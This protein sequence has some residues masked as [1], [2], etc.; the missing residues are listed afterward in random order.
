MN[1]R[2]QLRALADHV[3]ILPDYYDICGVRHFTD[4][5]TYVSL[6]QTLSLGA[7]TEESAERTLA[8]LERVER[9]R[10]LPPVRVL[11][12]ES[13]RRPRVTLNVPNPGAGSADWEIE[14]IEES[15][16]VH[17]V[18]SRGIEDG[19]VIDVELPGTLP[20]GYHT[21]R[22]TVD[23][24]TGPVEGEQSFIVTPAS[25]TSYRA[26]TNGRRAYGVWTNAYTLRSERNW[27]VGDL[28]DIAELARG[29]AR[30]G[31]LFVGLNPLHALRNR[32]DEV[33]PY[34]PISRLFR[35]FIYVDVEAVP[36]LAEC[37]EA[38]A[39]CSSPDFRAELAR[40]HSS[41]RVEYEH[42]ATIKR[43]VLR[44]LHRWFVEHHVNSASPRGRAFAEY[45]VAQGKPLVNFATFLAI[46]DRFLADGRGGSGWRD[47]PGEYHDPDSPAVQEFRNAHL[48]EIEFHQYVQFELDRQ[49]AV[50]GDGARQAG[51]SL[52]LYQDLAIGAAD[53]GSD[54][55]SFPGLF[56]EGI[57]VGAPPDPYSD[58]GQTWGFP[59]VNP[60]RLRDGAYD[61]WI[62]LLRSATAHTK[63]L[64]IDHVMG[65]FRQFWVPRGTTAADGAYVKFP[66][67]DLLGILALES[68][69]NGTVVVGEDLGTVPPEVPPKLKE[70]H[71]LS[72]RV[73]YFERDH[74]NEYRSSDSY[75]PRA[76]VTAT[77]HDHPPL[78]G[79]Q[80]G[81]DLDIRREIGLIASD[82]EL[83]NARAERAESLA[84]L[85][86][87]L[88]QEGF[89][90]EDKQ[91][92][93]DLLCAAVHAFVAATPSP[94]V[95]VSL[96]DLAGETD[97]IN[98][99][100]VV[101]ADYPSWTRR[102]HRNLD[103]VLADPQV[104][105]I[106]EDV[107][108]RV[109]AKTVPPGQHTGEDR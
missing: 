40:A 82:E 58:T 83:E 95:G 30:C 84:A 37:P 48:D 93:P 74:A 65:L 28:T 68:R 34:C 29:L 5:D 42:V 3:G 96:D 97:P 13:K 86:R 66:A 50:A 20:I 17:L 36:E 101:P 21:L 92:R 18:R 80:A 12:P 24:A 87:R 98:L 59:P 70:Y 78:A 27:G 43:D 94:L 104:W 4:D 71:I 52:G 85:A 57:E 22:A 81:R 46:E 63:M 16:A 26:H 77:N 75:S 79:F 38:Q 39:K 55:W 45:Q 99:P 76:L 8:D 89:L 109:S 100:G 7:S 108:K 19:G 23:L 49:L 73:M 53:N 61:Y 44:L 72:T 33:G 9:Q 54:A 60:H 105:R 15:G 88:V 69:R 31:A 102:M 51:M 103:D 1:S 91:D 32:G 25:C 62:R 14:L 106:L 2:S 64:R 41:A 35:N 90:A 6:L 11:R 67:D 10:L 56:V 47:W 107:R